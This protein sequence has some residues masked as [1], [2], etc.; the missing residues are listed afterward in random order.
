MNIAPVY[1]E[2]QQSVNSG[3]VFSLSREQLEQF[4]A[5]LSRASAYTQFSA[6]EFP[7]TCETVRMALSMRVSEDANLLAKKESRIALVVSFAALAVG[8]VSAISAFL[9]LAFPSPTQVYATPQ[10]PVYAVQTEQS[11][12][13]MPKP[14][15]QAPSK[16]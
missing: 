6:S 5:A 10:K 3:T 12:G 7:G 8:L 9:T 4:V 14:E 2:I 15:D 11:S 13:A 1:L 16:P